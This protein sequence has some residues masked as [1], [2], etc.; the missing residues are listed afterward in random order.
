MRQLLQFESTAKSLDPMDDSDSPYVQDHDG[1]VFLKKDLIKSGGLRQEDIDEDDWEY[2]Y[3]I[4]EEV[5]YE[6]FL[7]HVNITVKDRYNADIDWEKHGQMLAKKNM[8]HLDHL[9][10]HLIVGQGQDEFDEEGFGEGGEE[11]EILSDVY[12]FKFMDVFDIYFGLLTGALNTLPVE[13]DLNICGKNIK[14]QS[15][16]VTEMLVYIEVRDIV[17]TIDRMSQS[18]FYLNDTVVYC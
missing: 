6:H 4:E 11:K 5:K 7:P 15:F 17:Q 1:N 13:S 3:V 10:R 9:T 12:E 14:S 8:T 2:Q 18:L 16:Y